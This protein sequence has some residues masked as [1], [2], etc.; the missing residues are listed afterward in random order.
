MIWGESYADTFG[1]NPWQDIASAAVAP[2]SQS[3]F[4]F[5]NKFGGAPVH[6]ISSFSRRHGG[7]RSEEMLWFGGSYLWGIF[8]SG[9]VLFCHRGGRKKGIAL[10]VAIPWEDQGAAT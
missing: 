2:T 5:F 7:G 1:L 3:P 6:S 10:G 4:I 8:D 9:V